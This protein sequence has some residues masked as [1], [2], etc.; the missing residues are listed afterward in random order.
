VELEEADATGEVLVSVVV[1]SVLSPSGWRDSDI[2]SECC[3]CFGCC[4]C[5]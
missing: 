5:E 3:I 2:D 4:C 1:D